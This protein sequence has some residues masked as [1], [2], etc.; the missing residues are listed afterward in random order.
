MNQI[1]LTYKE[2]D[3][4]K[5]EQGPGGKW[6]YEW[7]SHTE[8]EILQALSKQY[9][10]NWVETV[11]VDFD[12]KEFKGQPVHIVV[13][14]YSTG[15]TFGHGTGRWQIYGV[16]TDYKDAVVRKKLVQKYPQD[17]NDQKL[18]LPYAYW[19]GYFER[20][21]NCYIETRTLL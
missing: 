13:V 12:P 9:D 18:G 6:D 20:F 17:I 3:D 19:T 10:E 1:Y 5:I 14:R 15:D 4:H 7:E 16:F 8:F 2:D 11:D 21:E